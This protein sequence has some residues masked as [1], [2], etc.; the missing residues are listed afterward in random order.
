MDLGVSQL[1][2]TPQQREIVVHPRSRMLD[3][4]P[5]GKLAAVLALMSGNPYLFGVGNDIVAPRNT[6]R[7]DCTEDAFVMPLAAPN[8]NMVARQQRFT[9]NSTGVIGRTEGRIRTDVPRRVLGFR[10]GFS[11]LVYHFQSRERH[12]LDAI[13]NPRHALGQRFPPARPGRSLHVVRMLPPCLSRD[14]D[15]MTSG[16]VKVAP[17]ATAR[18]SMASTDPPTHAL[19]P[20]KTS[21]RKRRL[22]AS[23]RPRRSASF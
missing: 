9:G 20:A 16:G 5:G 17:L 6:K 10:H 4:F 8:A 3:A 19:G 11:P 1:N 7:S 2:C 21:R 22:D 12:T 23:G 14:H 18:G 13:T 15:P